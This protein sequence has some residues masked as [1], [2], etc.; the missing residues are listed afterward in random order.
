MASKERWIWCVGHPAKTTTFSETIQKADRGTTDREDG[1]RGWWIL[2][3]TEGRETAVGET[4]VCVWNS[5]AEE[6][7]AA[8]T[9]GGFA[10]G[11]D[12]ACE[13][14]EKTEMDA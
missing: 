10:G 1:A 14:G 13:E 4:L 11:S 7:V 3:S 8:T 5:G 2:H 6:F 9:A 12:N